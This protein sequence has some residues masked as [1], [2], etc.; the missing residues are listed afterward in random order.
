MTLNGQGDL[1]LNRYSGTGGTANAYAFNT[2]SDERVKQ[3]IQ[4][5]KGPIMDK[6]MKLNPV[7]YNYSVV[8]YEPSQKLEIKSEAYP[9]LQSGF[10][11]QEVYRLFPDA[12]RK[13]NDETKDLW[14]IDYS[15]LTVV[16]T[17]A[18]QEQQLM[19]LDQKA[20]IENLKVEM[21]KLKQGK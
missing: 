14:A 18:M 15:K 12:V 19:I 9:E 13:P 6:V 17:K 4:K 5:L 20:E 8:D 10:L 2:I 1:T 7:T 21:A 11:A 16:L 3:H